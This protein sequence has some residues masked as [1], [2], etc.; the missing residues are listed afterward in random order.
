MGQFMDGVQYRFKATGLDVFNFVLKVMTG[1]FV[2]LTLALIGQEMIGFGTFSFVLVITVT[3][4]AFLKV[5]KKWSILSVLVFNLVCV[6]VGMLLR[7]YIL[8][9]PGH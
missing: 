7:M 8:L 3:L 4:L 6:L 5:A 9:A 1:S 2:G